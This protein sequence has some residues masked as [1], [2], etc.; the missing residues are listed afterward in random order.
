[1]RGLLPWI[2]K[3]FRE[4]ILKW[5]RQPAAQPLLSELTPSM[6]EL[7]WTTPE[8]ERLQGE[9]I[10]RAATV[11]HLELRETIAA[12]LEAWRANPSEQGLDELVSDIRRHVE[13]GYNLLP[14]EYVILEVYPCGLVKLYGSK[15]V[16][17]HV[18]ERP[19][20]LPEHEP[21]LDELVETQVPLLYQETYMPGM[22]RA[23]AFACSMTIAEIEY[24]KKLFNHVEALAK[25]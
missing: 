23:V 5:L 7:L 8:G 18:I 19:V 1:M 17:V 6:H 9:V 22:V 21:V 12:K 24:R 3:E 16:R 2:F 20:V 10:E 14:P 15:Q 13:R 4:L 25:L 11:C